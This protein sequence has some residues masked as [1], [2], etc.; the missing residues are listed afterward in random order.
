M[1]CASPGPP[2]NPQRPDSGSMLVAGTTALPTMA[3]GTVPWLFW[4]MTV[5]AS[6]GETSTITT[7]GIEQS[8]KAAS[9]WNLPGCASYAAIV[10]PEGGVSLPSPWLGWLVPARVTRAALANDPGGVLKPLGR[11]LKI[12]PAPAGVD[13]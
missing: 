7:L 3:T 10:P 4:L 1:T 13:T 8:T 9:R 6:P 12:V 2:V 11:Y 5:P